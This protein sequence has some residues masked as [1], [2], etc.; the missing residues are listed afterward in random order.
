MTCSQ[1][2]GLEQETQKWVEEDLKAYRR[3]KQSPTTTMLIRE[4]LRRGVGG[5]TLLDIGGGIGEIPL[6]L[7]AGG[8]ASA[9]NVEI[10]TAYLNA[11]RQ[12]SARKGLAERITLVHGDFVSLADEVPAA[13]IVTLNKVVCCYPDFEALVK[14]SSARARKYYGVV[15][16]KDWWVLRTAM[17][18]INWFS[19]AQKSLYVAYIHPVAEVDR[20]IRASGLVPVYQKST[21]GWLVRVYERH[22]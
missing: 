15:F 18:V 8:A 19:K 5:S 20:L 6:E 3:G 7:L 22:S 21:L 1:C 4:L 11:A 2:V 17:K 13:D 12:E 10:S 16:P 14:K 9:T